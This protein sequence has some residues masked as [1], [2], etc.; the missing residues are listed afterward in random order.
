MV[1]HSTAASGTGTVRCQYRR[2]AAPARYLLRT[3]QAAAA[4]LGHIV[5]STLHQASWEILGAQNEAIWGFET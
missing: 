5:R 1:P 3:Y 4:W 2:P